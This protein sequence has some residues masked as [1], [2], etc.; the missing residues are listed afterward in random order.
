[1]PDLHGKTPDQAR[2][3]LR[4][5]GLQLGRQTQAPDLDKVGRILRSTPVAG[6]PAPLGSQVGYVLAV[7]PV[8]VVPWV[9]GL[10]R[11]EAVAR[12]HAAGLKAQISNPPWGA[13]PINRVDRQDPPAGAE[14]R[15][16]QPVRLILAGS[17][18]PLAAGALAAAGLLA[19]AG[20]FAWSHTWPLRT[21]VTVALGALEPVGAGAEPRADH[22]TVNLHWTVDVAAA[23]AREGPSPVIED[24][25]EEVWK[26][27]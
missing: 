13:W 19:A 7:K 9:V 25:K 26:G 16:D 11:S 15:A 23:D 22:P 27:S 5:V 6:A 17:V 2:E 21:R 18:A 10:P 4:A 3:V 14:A 8:D 1:V 20:A 12:L 24:G